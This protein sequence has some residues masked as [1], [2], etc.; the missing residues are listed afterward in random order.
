MNNLES[1]TCGHSVNC[2]LRLEYKLA[3][4]AAGKCITLD[5]HLMFPGSPAEGG[6]GLVGLSGSWRI[7]V[8][9]ARALL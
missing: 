9:A 8:L 5:L 6:P 2:I 3:N 1:D 7:T 4:A